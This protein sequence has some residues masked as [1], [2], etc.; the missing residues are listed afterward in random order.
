[1]AKILFNTMDGKLL[2]YPRADEEPVMGLS[3]ILQV[4]T[5]IQEEYPTYNTATHDIS[6]KEV[7]DIVTNVVT[8]G[9]TVTP[10]DVITPVISPFDNVKYNII[11]PARTFGQSLIDDFSTE[12]VLLGITQSGKTGIIGDAL[13]D[14][15]FWITTGSLFEVLKVI[16]E[17]KLNLNTEWEPF[18]TL[19]RLTMVENKIKLYLNIT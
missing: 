5:L 6:K 17:L 10:K 4:M 11:I 2:P 1:M 19:E 3:P 9:W 12:N 18:I 7:I 13:R 16:A 14:I 15:N 8:R